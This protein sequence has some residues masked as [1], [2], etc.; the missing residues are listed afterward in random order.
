MGDDLGVGLG[1]EPMAL[2]GE[3]LAQL[4]IVFDDA[5]VHNGQAGRTVDVRVR[6]GVGGAPM[7]RPAGM[8]N[9]HGP[10]GGIFVEDR[11]EPGDL[12]HGFP[13]LQG[14]SVDRR[15]AGRIVAPVLQASESGEEN[16]QG[17]AWPDVADYPA[18]TPPDSSKTSGVSY[19]G[20][21][22]DIM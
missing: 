1:V 6:I 18:H 7:G 10:P 21:Y 14:A 12:P 2:A 13:H 19:W 20:R 11:L 3:G 8:G 9:A 15:D 17:L 5:V 4:P 22:A 16:G